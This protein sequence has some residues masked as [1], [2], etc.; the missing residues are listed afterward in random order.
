[1]PS[2]GEIATTDARSFLDLSLPIAGIAGDQPAAL[3]GQAC[4][5]AGDTRCGYDAGASVLTST[6]AALPPP[7][8]GLLR[9]AAWRS[10]GGELTYALEGALPGPG[11][12]PE[13]VASQVRDVL[14][15]LPAALP[16]PGVVRVDGA[17]AADDLLCQRQAD[18]L[19]VP[20][21]RPAVL[22]A[23]GLGAAFLA[24][25]GA[26]VWASTDQLRDAWR[27]DRRFAPRR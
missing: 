25:L 9:T 15:A 13:A 19:G 27:L 17:A 2:W 22:E 1:M 4:F 3:F 10:P 7:V 24:G 26:G 14:A 23:P 18:R 16:S 5:D 20:V 12:A 6:G 21:E 11:A 8:A